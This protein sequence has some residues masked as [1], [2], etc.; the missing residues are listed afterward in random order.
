[1]AVALL[2]ASLGTS[3]PAD[4]RILLSTRLVIR[5]SSG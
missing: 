5:A 4:R 1:M 3:V 2:R